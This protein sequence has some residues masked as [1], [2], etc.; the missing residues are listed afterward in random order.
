MKYIAFLIILIATGCVSVNLGAGPHPSIER[1]G[2][3]SFGDSIQVDQTEVR[4]AEWIEFMQNSDPQRIGSF[5]NRKEHSEEELELIIRTPLDETFLPAPS[6]PYYTLLLNLLD[7]HNE[8]GIA[9]GAGSSSNTNLVLN[10]A[11][12]SDSTAQILNSPITGITFQQA[13]DFCAWRT[14]VDNLRYEESSG[15]LE[16]GLISRSI[17]DALTFDIDSINKLGERTFNYGTNSLSYW[18]EYST[19]LEHCHNGLWDMYGNAAEMLNTNGLAVGGS[20]KSTASDCLARGT[21]EY[22]VSSPEVGF[23]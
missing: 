20:Y 22:A 17:Y 3:L 2:M 11:Y 6:Y 9:S 21:M 4:L 23:R 13:K 14:Q 15:R 8:Q 18:K 7:L 19:N 16:F 1:Y 10:R 5:I 12:F